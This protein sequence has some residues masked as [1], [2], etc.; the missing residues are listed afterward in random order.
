MAGSHCH[1]YYDDKSVHTV[2]SGHEVISYCE[3]VASTKALAG[4]VHDSK[5]LCESTTGR[6]KHETG[7]DGNLHNCACATPSTSSA[8]NNK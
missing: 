3:E 1:Y 6:N 5:S 7:C 2:Y 8:D 4:S